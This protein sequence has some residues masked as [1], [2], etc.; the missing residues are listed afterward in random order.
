MF[1]GLTLALSVIAHTYNS[2]GADTASPYTAFLQEMQRADIDTRTAVTFTTNE[3]GRISFRVRCA[4]EEE[5]L[6]VRDA[7][8]KAV[9][10]ANCTKDPPTVSGALPVK[11]FAAAPQPPSANGSTASG[12]LSDSGYTGYGSQSSSY[13]KPSRSRSSPGT[14]VYVHEYRKKDGTYVRSHTRS[15]PSK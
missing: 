14:D 3:A 11:S 4:N 8:L 15:R 6:R 9:G 10:A 12:S 7:V 1:L 5:R 13:S 2:L